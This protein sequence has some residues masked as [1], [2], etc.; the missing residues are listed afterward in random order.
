MEIVRENLEQSFK[1]EV[2]SF[3]RVSGGGYASGE[4]GSPT[5]QCSRVARCLPILVLSVYIRVGGV[6][7]LKIR[8]VYTC[9]SVMS[10]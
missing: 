5:T 3:E 10:S 8:G 9:T 7:K 4:G 6:M 1:A 2:G